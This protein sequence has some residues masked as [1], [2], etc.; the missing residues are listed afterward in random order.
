[1]AQADLGQD[2][3]GPPTQGKEWRRVAIGEIATMRLGGNYPSTSPRT[4]RAL[5]K[6]GN[7]ARVAIDLHKVEYIPETEEVDPNHRL[8]SGDVILNTRNTLD[9]VGKVSIWRDQ[10]PRAYY[11]SNILRFEF[12]PDTCGSSAYFGYALN[13]DSSIR[14][15]RAMAKGTTSVGAIYARDLR[16]LEIDLPPKDEQRAITTALS[17]ADDLIASLERL[18]AKKRDIK[19]AVMQ[20]LLT[21][22]T[23]LLGFEGQWEASSL[24]VIVSK[25]S[26]YWGLTQPAGDSD[27]PVAVIRA[28]DISDDSCLLGSAIRYWTDQEFSRASC[29][30]GDVAM[31]SSGNGLGKVWMSDGRRI[32]VS[33]FV[34]RLRPGPSA[35]GPFLFHL[36][37][38][39]PA[40]DALARHTA[41]SAYP[42]LRPSFFSESWFNLPPMDE[43]RAIARVL[44]DMDAEI[45]AS[46]ARLAKTRDI[47]IGMMQELLTGRTRLPIPES[48]EAGSEADGSTDADDDLV[49]RPTDSPPDSVG[50]HDPG[51]SEAAEAVA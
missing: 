1:M 37:R 28:G 45:E 29:A 13:S 20:Q 23:R 46:E 17:D 40:R 14:A 4:S 26:G 3:Q 32:A 25:T 50:D 44:S 36:L 11:N 38:S 47:K 34:K 30:E 48:V 12:F 43:Q 51:T 22:R 33:N 6:M 24:S 21:G 42:N 19:Q 2:N 18:I 27:V 8:M 39:D 16:K 5:I 41:T 49:A 35:H 15:I 10:L 7:I 9:L 31:T